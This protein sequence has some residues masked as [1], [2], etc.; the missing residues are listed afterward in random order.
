M[1]ALVEIERDR[2]GRPQKALLAITH[3]EMVTT[4]R[5]TGELLQKSSIRE[6]CACVYRLVGF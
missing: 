4:V 3:D 5:G 1:K 6:V 2:V